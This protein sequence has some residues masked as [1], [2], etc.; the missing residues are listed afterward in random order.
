MSDIDVEAVDVIG[1]VSSINSDVV[2]A[3]NII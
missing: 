3:Y 1:S 2:A